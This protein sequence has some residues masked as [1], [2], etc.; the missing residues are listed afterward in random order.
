AR[1]EQERKIYLWSRQ[2]YAS[3]RDVSEWN[4]AYRQI[5]YCNVVLHGLT[6]VTP[7]LS[8]VP[9]HNQLRGEALFYRS[10]AFYNLA[11]LFAPPFDAQKSSNQLGI[12]LRLSPDV[13]DVT[14]RSPLNEVYQRIFADL[15]EASQLLPQRVSEQ[16]FP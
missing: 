11:Q 1:G 6:N 14:I 3:T 4:D 12:P 10:R 8:E 7:A 9:L 2:F 5:S 13:N 16:T 15:T